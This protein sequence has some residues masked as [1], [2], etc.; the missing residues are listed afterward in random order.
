L[1]AIDLATHTNKASDLPTIALTMHA[2]KDLPA[3]NVDAR[4]IN[5]PVIALAARTC[6][7]KAITLAACAGNLPAV[8]LAAHADKAGNLSAIALVARVDKDMPVV[9]LDVRAGNLSALAFAVPAG[10]S[11][12]AHW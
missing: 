9:A 6:N 7:S 3:V 2:D 1:P 5:L 4:A 11:L 10:D 12:A 8:T